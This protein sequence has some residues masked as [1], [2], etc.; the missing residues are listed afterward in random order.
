MLGMDS[1][2]ESADPATGSVKPKSPAAI[3]AK[4]GLKSGPL[5]Q[6]LKVRETRWVKIKTPLVALEIP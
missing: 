5:G 4:D 6:E 1:A 3:E 2:A